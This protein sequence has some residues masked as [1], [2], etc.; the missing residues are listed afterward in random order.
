VSYLS[1]Q[2]EGMVSTTKATQDTRISLGFSLGL[3]VSYL[4]QQ[5][6]G[7]VSTTKATHDTRISVRMR[8]KKR[9]AP[10]EELGSP[11]AFHTYVFVCVC[12]CMC[13][14]GCHKHATR[15]RCRTKCR[16]RHKQRH[17]T[18]FKTRCVAGRSAPACHV[19]PRDRDTKTRQKNY[20][21]ETKQ[22]NYTAKLI[23]R[24]SA[25]ARSLLQRAGSRRVSAICQMDTWQLGIVGPQHYHY[26]TFSYSGVAWLPLD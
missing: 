1:Q 24:V 6:E 5:K 4:P 21:H 14:C 11:S 10:L 23:W 3:T 16:R 8:Q 2:K 20:Y 7:M 25:P 15:P 19:R 12:V 9:Y 17:Q 22:S 18:M 26:S 13:V